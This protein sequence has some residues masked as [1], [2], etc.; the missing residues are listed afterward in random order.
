MPLFFSGSI[1]MV[2]AG[3]FDGIAAPIYRVY[4]D[5]AILADY[6]AGVTSSHIGRQDVEHVTDEGGAG[7]V[8]ELA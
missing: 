4:H 6:A 5:A 1:L 3:M 2:V 8:G 7:A